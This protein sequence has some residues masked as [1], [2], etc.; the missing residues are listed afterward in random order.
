MLGHTVRF[1]MKKVGLECPTHINTIELRSPG[2][3]SAAVPTWSIY[4]TVLS[5]PGKKWYGGQ[6]PLTDTSQFFN[7]L[8]ALLVR[9]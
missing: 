8:T 2:Q 7:C 6:G 9:F 3:P 1:Q 5:L 4:A